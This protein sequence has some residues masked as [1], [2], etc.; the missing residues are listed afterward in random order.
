MSNDFSLRLARVRESAA[1]LNT[2]CDE[3]AQ[4]VKGL[5]EFLAKECSV[6]I[7]AEVRVREEEDEYH[8]EYLDLCYGRWGAQFRV[9]L[10]WT[11]TSV[12]HPHGTET[13]AWVECK[14]EDK[15]ETLPRLLDLVADIEEKLQ[16]RIKQAKDAI[17][18]VQLLTSSKTSQVTTDPILEKCLKLAKD[19]LTPKPIV[20]IKRKGGANERQ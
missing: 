20:S 11:D 5:E 14:R 17:S 3:G 6:G 12:P 4:C 19:A 2:L 9:F 15:L 16:S 1:T 8:G 10:K 13:K 18:A 7:A